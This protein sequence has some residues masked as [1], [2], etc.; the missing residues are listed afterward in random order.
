MIARLGKVYYP[1]SFSVSMPVLQ[2]AALL[3]P[4]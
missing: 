4:A 3:A 1:N 2:G